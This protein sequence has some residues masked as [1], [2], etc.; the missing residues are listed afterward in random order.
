MRKMLIR[1]KALI[2]ILLIIIL[3]TSCNKDKSDDIQDKLSAVEGEN[4]NAGSA[5]S[6]DAQATYTYPET[7]N[8]VSNA[9]VA[10]DQKTIIDAKVIAETTEDIGVYGLSFVPIDEELVKSYADKL[11]DNSEYKV[12]KPFD[13]CNEE[14]LYAEREHVTQLI[15]YYGGESRAGQKYYKLPCMTIPYAP[16]DVINSID[17]ELSK[18]EESNFVE[19]SDGQLLYKET[20]ESYEDTPD[21]S[22]TT[23]KSKT[24][25]RGKVDGEEWDMTVQ[26]VEPVGG[27]PYGVISMSNVYSD[28]FVL[29]YEM[30][31]DRNTMFFGENVVDMGEA[32]K[33][34][35]DA[36][37]KL[38]F[39]EID[40][41]YTYSVISCDTYTTENGYSQS[42]GEKNNGY[43]F[44]FARR[45][46]NLDVGYVAHPYNSITMTQVYGEELGNFQEYI[47]VTVTDDGIYN[48]SFSTGYQVT[49][50]LSEESILMD[51][52]SIN[53]MA[54]KYIEERP[55]ICQDIGSIEL[56]Y[57]ATY[58]EDEGY[59]LVPVWVYYFSMDFNK[60]TYYEEPCAR[61]GVNA[62]D[63][64]IVDFIWTE[65]PFD[66]DLY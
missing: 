20:R 47:Y 6:M 51:F 46:G 1:K 43:C 27:V 19:L 32:K 10:G 9:N 24:R 4:I 41:I 59:A 50:K 16:E 61:F 55:I 25:L 63:G 17:Y 48:I 45:Y 53:D 35:T 2:T 54:V 30:I 62:L 7:V 64:S 13:I 42:T 29:N 11:F 34:A 3:C 26:Y 38:G 65:D 66:I 21:D 52:G 22:I 39:E 8:Y 40:N 31:N 14:E 60:A 44:V 58:Y 15:E 18:Y 49:D 36:L 56:K 33:D 28:T 5:T 23:R 12:I 57:I 37:N